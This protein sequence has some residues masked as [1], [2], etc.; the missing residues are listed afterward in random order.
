MTE[1]SAPLLRKLIELEK[2]VLLNIINQDY[3]KKYGF[4]IDRKNKDINLMLLELKEKNPA[5]QAHRLI[6]SKII[7]EIFF[8]KSRIPTKELANYLYCFRKDSDTLPFDLN[9]KNM[10]A[11]CPKD[12]IAFL[13]EMLHIEY[14]NSE[15]IYKDGDIVINKSKVNFKDKGSVYTEYKI[16][17]EI[18]W[19]T[20]KNKLNQGFPPE[21]L[22]ILDF[23][24]GTGRFYE[25]AFKYLSKVLKRDKRKIISKHLFGIDVDSLALDILK[26]KILSFL[27]SYS[28]SDLKLISK[29]IL[30]KNMLIA[31]DKTDSPS[32]VSYGNDFRA[33]ISEGGFNIILSNPPYFL[34]KVNKK[35]NDNDLIND[36]YES[37]T[38][39]VKEEIKFFRESDLYKYSIEGMLNYYRIS[40]DMILN[41]ADKYA[42]IGIICPATLFADLSSKKLR[43]YLLLENKIRE[44]DYFPE[45]ARLF[46][47]ISQS[48]V[49]F[50]T[51]KQG[52]TDKIRIKLGKRKFLI[53]LDLIHKSFG[54]NYE[55]PLIDRTG[56]N[57]L[58]KLASFKK[59]KDFD[60]I[61]NKRGELDLTLY[62]RLIT[63][64]N[65]GYR[66]VRGNMISGAEILKKNG[67]YVLIKQ[68]LKKKSSE[69]IANGFNKIR[70][71]CQQ[72]SNTEIPKRLNFVIC[73]KKDILA[74][75]CN[76]ILVDDERYLPKIRTLL[77]S[78]ILNWR[79]KVSSSNNHINNYEL[80]TLPMLDAKIL[81]LK[82]EDNELKNNIQIGKLYGLN[83]L[84]MKYILKEYFDAKEV[85]RELTH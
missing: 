67:E 33:A 81:D 83:N 19:K 22:R 64:E 77:N 54:E 56:W 31:T 46:N 32:Y 85:D 39:R 57:I 29:N 1:K 41:I 53:S 38:K 78:Y 3:L 11:K 8:R 52:K 17:K 68:F 72:V 6:I 15:Y 43:K 20:I 25:A 10:L 36:Y 2:K 16:S 84:E 63:K 24:C 79:F 30:N 58:K 69:Y 26:I 62:K 34:L 73:D 4:I 12:R 23:G 80:D 60:Y 74:N 50:Y 76:Y 40:I 42:E 49:I 70:L 55:I 65:T 7:Y 28:L 21:K 45:S 44:I 18:T 75:S 27:N 61:T 71:I 82:L 14:L 66:L 13:L 51:Q 37:L 48:T 5:F 35:N 47:G 9:I 59:L